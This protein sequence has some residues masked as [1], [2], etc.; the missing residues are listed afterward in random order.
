LSKKSRKR[1]SG[2][3]LGTGT[4]LGTLALIISIGALGLGIY[5]IITPQS[6]GPQFYIVEHDD[7]IYFDKYTAFD[8]LNELSLTYTTNVGS[9]VVLEFSCRIFMPAT[10]QTNFRLKFDNNGSI[11]STAIIVSADSYFQT[12]EYM[13]YT[14]EASASGENDIVVYATCDYEIDNII[15]DS[16]LTVTV[17]G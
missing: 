7:P 15:Y 11:P 8:Y 5:Q 6:T 4:T 17:Y 3:N 16:L 2:K 1:K 13:R 12:T 14:F 10:S 9:M